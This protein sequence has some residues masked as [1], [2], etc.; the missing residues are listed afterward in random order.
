MYTGPFNDSSGVEILVGDRVAY[1]YSGNV[2]YGIVRELKP[3][4]LSYYDADCLA[5]FPHNFSSCKITI[6]N[7]RRGTISVVKNSKGILVI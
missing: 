4:T 2:E 3:I 1:N 7:V 5:R 6:Y